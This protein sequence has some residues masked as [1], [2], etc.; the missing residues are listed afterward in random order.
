[1]KYINKN[2]QQLDSKIQDMFDLDM[3]NSAFKRVI[4]TKMM[5]DLR[6]QYVE[7]VEQSE[8]TR[9]V[10]QNSRTVSTQVIKVNIAPL[11]EAGYC[12]CPEEL[13][14]ACE[15]LLKQNSEAT[16]AQSTDDLNNLTDDQQVAKTETADVDM[17]C[18]SDS[19][20]SKSDGNESDENE[21]EKLAKIIKQKVYPTKI[22]ASASSKT[23]SD[24][25]EKAH[26]VRAQKKKKYFTKYMSNEFS[27]DTKPV[28][29]TD[30]DSKTQQLFELQQF[31]EL[32]TEITGMN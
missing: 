22:D 16:V 28:S 2:V 10:A 4:P 6:R 8:A 29:M 20:S 21:P 17:A 12:C 19:T 25:N 15:Q 1:M 26:Q 14:A 32:V 7:Y 31:N 13:A 23:I 11:R 5:G 30:M 27:K 24:K 9:Q 18:Q 3:P